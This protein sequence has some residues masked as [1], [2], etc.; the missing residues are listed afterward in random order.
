MDK[1]ISKISNLIKGFHQQMESYLPALKLEV[2]QII[3]Q[4]KTNSSEIE[5][6]LDTLLSLSQHGIGNALFIK[7]LEYYKTIDEEGARFYWEEYD[8]LEE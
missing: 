3:T 5:N 1:L 7:L 6:Y 2:S 4:K 8:K